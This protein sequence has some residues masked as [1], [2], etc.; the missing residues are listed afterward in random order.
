VNEVNDLLEQLVL[1]A[2]T[3]AIREQTPVQP[4]DPFA[5]A[6]AFVAALVREAALRAQQRIH[7]ASRHRQMMGAAVAGLAATRGVLALASILMGR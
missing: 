2:A 3:R 7:F 1:G 6:G 4:Q 5:D